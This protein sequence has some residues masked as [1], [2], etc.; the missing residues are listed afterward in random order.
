MFVAT[1]GNDAATGDAAHPWRSLAA[2]GKLRLL[3]GDTIHLRAGDEWREPLVLRGAGGGA[4]LAGCMD[5]LAPAAGSSKADLWVEGWALDC[6]DGDSGRSHGAHGCH[7]ANGSAPLPPVQISAQ[8]D[9][10]EVG[11]AMA[12]LSRPDLQTA[13]A[14]PDPLHGFNMHMQLDPKYLRGQHRLAV[15]VVGCPDCGTG[16]ALP[17]SA[18]CLCDGSL[19]PC[20]SLPP[21]SAPPAVRVLSTDPSGQRPIIRLNGLAT[22]QDDA[23]WAIH[24]TGVASVSVESLAVE[25]ATSGISVVSPGGE[26]SAVEIKDCHF[27]EVWN[28]SSVGQRLPTATNQCSNGWS[29]CIVVG[30][31]ESVLVSGCIFQDFDV[32]FQPSGTLGRAR[33]LGNTLT[34]GNGNVVFLTASHD[35]LLSGNI[36][37]R[38]WA[39]RYFTCGTTDIMIGGADSKGAI[40]HNEIGWRGEHPAAPDGCAIDYEGES[41]GV[42]VTDNF[43]H[44]V[45]PAFLLY[46]LVD[47]PPCFHCIL[48]RISQG[49]MCIIYN[50]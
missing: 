40:S 32:A 9:G 14:A 43:I 19:C 50:I 2:L 16:W 27:K 25:H 38:D 35:W 11:S 45:S 1:D 5:H 42:N 33:F 48:Q 30:N 49:V 4:G 3:P 34:A 18:K 26:S 46:I 10:V 22:A 29:P 6:R 13:G 23:Q 8:V 20:T 36:F 41:T 7:L 37:T 15:R 24:I 47:P 12:N 17:G 44:D 31:V 39:P 28:R 21:T